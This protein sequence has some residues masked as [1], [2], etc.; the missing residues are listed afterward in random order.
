[1][2]ES[3]STRSISASFQKVESYLY[4]INRRSFES[5]FADF[6]KVLNIAEVSFSRM[7]PHRTHFT[8]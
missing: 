7:E 2:T 5:C 8:H 4:L 3:I 1:M 6:F